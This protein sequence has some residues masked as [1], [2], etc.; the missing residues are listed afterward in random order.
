MKIRHIILFVVAAAIAALASCSKTDFAQEGRQYRAISF[1]VAR[2]AVR[3]GSDTTDYASEFAEVPFG[4]YAWFKGENPAND[5][6]FMSRQKVAFDG[7]RWKTVGITYYWPRSGSLDFISYS[8]YIDTL[9]SVPAVTE[10]SISWTNWSVADHPTTDLMYATK[11]VGQTDNMHS[12]YYS[13]VPTLFHHALARVGV[14]VRLAYSEV[15]APTGDKTR[16]D[17]T[18]H[19]IRLRN[20]RTAG[21]LTLHL[22]ADGKN[23]NPPDSN[24]W[25]P[26]GTPADIVLDCSS[27]PLLDSTATFEVDTTRLVLPQPLS[28]GQL[29][30]F[31]LTIRSWRDTGAGYQLFLTE[32][33]VHVTAPLATTALPRWGI[34][35]SVTYTFVLAPSL[36]T[37]NGTD[38]EPTVIHFDPAV[39]D[40]EN[41]S[42]NTNINI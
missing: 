37:D 42:L 2:Y 10:N 3:A 30:D 21:S 19:G 20:I 35:Q 24:T 26:A 31:D 17:V 33:H 40:W 38:Q 14:R 8:P 28:G 39:G 25:A 34:N 36:P 15:E 9:T 13:G 4:T 27:L 29:V 32:D 6:V 41:V 23:W 22:N 12:Y 5:T 7:E 18:V 16:W 11:A 1:E